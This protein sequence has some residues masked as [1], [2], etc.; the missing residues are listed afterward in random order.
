M[1]IFCNCKTPSGITLHPDSF[2]VICADCSKPL[3]NGQWY[4]TG[5]AVSCST[6]I[7]LDPDSFTPKQ[8]RYRSIDEPWEDK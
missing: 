2:S 7:S 1:N 8:R 3:N 4:S 6:K 5:P